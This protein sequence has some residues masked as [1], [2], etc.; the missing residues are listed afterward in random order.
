MCAAATTRCSADAR[1]VRRDEPCRDHV[2]IEVT[3]ADFPPADP[4]QFLQLLCHDPEDNPDAAADWPEDGFPSLSNPDVL[5]PRAYLRRPFS[6]ADQWV[7]SAGRTHLCVLS[8]AIGV[9]TRWL[10]RLQPGDTLNITGPLGRGFGD[11]KARRPRV[12]VGGGVGIPPLL[13]LA[14]R[15]FETGQEDVTLIVGARARDLFPVPLVGE[16]DPA[17]GPL[18]CLALPA[19]APFPAIVTSDDGS[20]GLR[21]LVTDGL[22]RWH[23]GRSAAKLDATVLACGPDGMLKAVAGLTR[24]LGLACQLC[25]ERQM[26]CGLGT[27]LSCVVKQRDAQAPDG[28]TWKLACQDGPV[29]ERDALL[30]YGTDASA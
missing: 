1:V 9:G 12:L 21:G 8:H 24:E 20:L 10:D 30:D 14:R 18:S 11:L 19:A 29:F 13:F 16:P 15:L 17:G 23:A 7:D 3:V 4:G 28:W 26:G 6:I 25:I 27:C 22:R 2:W 5:V